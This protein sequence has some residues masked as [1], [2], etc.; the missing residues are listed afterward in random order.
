MFTHLPKKYTPVIL[1]ALALLALL[2]VA[3]VAGLDRQLD[4][5]WD[6][7]QPTTTTPAVIDTS[8]WKTYRN[9]EYGFEFK[10]PGDWEID[11]EARK[12]ENDGK[13]I[14]ELTNT[15]QNSKGWK[16]VGYFSIDVYENKKGIS[17]GEWTNNYVSVFYEVIENKQIVI[18]NQKAIYANLVDNEAGLEIRVLENN[19]N[20]FVIYTRNNIGYDELAFLEKHIKQ[21]K[22]VVNSFKF[23]VSE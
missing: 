18:N 15:I 17:L 3:I 22:E 16:L 5:L 11:N 20:F 1:V 14:L 13:V 21:E 6:N 9:E 4:F 2:V 7:K 23:I 10:Y 8:D 12:I 19:N